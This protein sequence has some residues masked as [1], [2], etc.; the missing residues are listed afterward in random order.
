MKKILSVTLLILFLF[1][2]S[3]LAA[4]NDFESFVEFFPMGS[5]DWDNGFFYGIGKG[6]PHLNRGSKARAIRVAQAGALSSILQVA[7][8]LRVDDSRILSDLEK[9]KIIIQIKAIVHYE[10][11]ERK[12]IT[13]KG[14]PYYSVTYRAPMRGVKGLTKLL[15]SQ[16]RTKPSLW[17]EL[18]RQEIPDIDDQSGPWL[19]LDARGI[20]K[21]TPVEPALFPK[22]MSA[23]GETIYGLQDVNEGA[24]EKRGMASYVVT[25]KSH[26]ELMAW[27]GSRPLTW[28][29]KL[30]SVQEA[31]A[32][33]KRRRRSRRGKYV[34]SN[35]HEAR[36]LMKTNLVISESDA[37]KLKSEDKSSRILSQCR[38]TVIVSESLG[39][40]EGAFPE[41][42]ASRR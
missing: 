15:I 9:Q 40:I 18:P 21:K 16:A 35:A 20:S 2:G 7:A 36:G 32:A 27:A 29:V 22:I 41:L 1:F 23:S 6:F 42:L 14:E 19:V 28:L 12:Y 13:G 3:A 10:P 4:D 11:F 31:Q 25:D 8:G 30:V 37:R 39:G 38:V 33:E 5:I 24:L 17:K 34:V 26:E